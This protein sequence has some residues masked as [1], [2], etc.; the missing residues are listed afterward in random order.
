M[1]TLER[2]VLDNLV[3][4]RKRAG[5]SQKQVE[6]QLALRAN[7]LYDIEKGRLKLPF[8]LAVQL[9]DCYHAPLDAL[10][11]DDSAATTTGTEQPQ[12]AVS[13]LAALGI[14]DSGIH[15][16]ANFIAQDP[17]IV[18]EIGVGQLGKKPLMEL[19][20]ANLTETQQQ[21]FVLDLYRYINSLISSDG[22]IRDSEIKLRD[23]LIAQA[24]VELSESDKKSIAR[25]FQK[26]F[27]GKSMA[28]SLPRN[29]YK[30]FLV[31]TLHLVSRSD[32]KVHYKARDYIHQVAEHIE[33][34]MSAFRFIEEQVATAY[35]DDV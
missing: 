2:Q 35:R 1:E 23:T 17:V 21:H 25:A 11:Q 27:F 10:I 26:P 5:L 6:T 30:H 14:I 18:A 29:A 24:Q 15:P 16:L 4:L 9:M 20:L 22:E 19:L 34:P 28:K 13:S 32:G 12:E 33:L 7:T 8:V 31:W 3:R